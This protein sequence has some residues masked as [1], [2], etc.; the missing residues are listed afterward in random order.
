MKKIFLSI[1]MI[2]ILAFYNNLSLSK[3]FSLVLNEAKIYYI[4]ELEETLSSI[5]TISKLA[6][7]TK[8]LGPE[9]RIEL[10]E[11]VARSR[12][13]FKRIEFLLDYLDPQSVY[14][15]INGAP[16]PKLEQHVPEINVL[17]PNGFQ[18]LDELVYEDELDQAKVL[19]LAQKLYSDFSKALDYQKTRKLQHRYLFE[20][21]RIGVVRLYN[22]GLTGFDTPGS[23][24]AI[25]ES[26]YVLE[27]MGIVF[28]AYGEV[29][30]R[31]DEEAYQEIM[32]T[33]V[34]FRNYLEENDD[35]DALDR[36][37]ILIEYVNPLFEKLLDFQKHLGIE[38]RYEAD[39]TPAP[40]N[41][42]ARNMFS[43]DFLRK[44]YYAGLS[45]SD[46][47]N[48]KKKALGAKLFYDPILSKD[49]NLSCASCHDPEKAFT[50]GLPK[51][52][53]SKGQAL[54]R[55]APT[56]INSV[57]ADRYFLDMRERSLERQ[58]KHVVMDENEFDIDFIELADRLKSDEDYAQQFHEAF[59]NED[60]YGVSS[61]SISHALSVYISSLTSFNSE[62]DDYVKNKDENIPSEIRNGYNL[63]MG[64]ATCGTCHFAPVFNGTVPPYY[65]ESESEVLGVLM[66][67]DTL[68][69]VLD[70]DPGRINNGITQEGADHYY[71]SFK[72]TT[73]RNSNVTGPY[74]HN[75]SIESLEEL[76]DFYNRGGG[77][78]FGLDVA[79]QTLPSN[80]LE[81]TKG[82]VSD[83]VSFM[84]SLDDYERFIPGVSR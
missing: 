65:K 55:N 35:F 10:Q 64:K 57:Y 4:S 14:Y 9:G 8:D 76:V 63:F 25:E 30:D 68:N 81:L 19:F 71:R 53:G 15:Y 3:N 11:A 80:R 46:L 70:A 69:P 49:M 60:R 18:T 67:Y 17:P 79:H 61:W 1:S 28:G 24:N 51:S 56:L 77:E 16:L 82:E 36:Y 74:M 21:L 13:N 78:G 37:Y 6:G 58:V 54:Q 75:G 32:S 12:N 38:M 73:V 50:D 84:K 23:G 83:L 27:G 31:E 5:Q 45:K 7:Q 44:E 34:S 26:R 39:P 52:K 59:G 42:S 40:L 41:L 62:F 48:K 22:L 33:L 2:G 72:T 43:D 47:E 20:S 66:T 29:I